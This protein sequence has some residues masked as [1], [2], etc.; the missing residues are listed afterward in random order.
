M[1]MTLRSMSQTENLNVNVFVKVFKTSLFPNLI[2]RFICLWF[3]DTYLSKILR[4]TISTTL[5]HVKVKVTEFLCL[6][7][8]SKFLVAHIF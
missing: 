7:F 6:N 4:R 3:D 5:G 8:T 2:T 1:T